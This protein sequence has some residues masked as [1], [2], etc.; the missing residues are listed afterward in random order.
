MT[1]A[2]SSS[3]RL[4]TLPSAFS[5]HETGNK[6]AMTRAIPFSKIPGEAASV[7]TNTVST[8]SFRSSLVRNFSDVTTRW[9]PHCRMHEASASADKV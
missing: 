3:V 4:R 8:G 9:M 5:I 1:V 6:S 7:S 2:K